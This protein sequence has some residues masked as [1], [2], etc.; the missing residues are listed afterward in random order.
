MQYEGAFFGV[1]LALVGVAIMTSRF[2]DEL[3]DSE[4]RYG[5]SARQRAAADIPRARRQVRFM[6]LVVGCSFIA[7][8]LFTALTDG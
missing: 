3:L 8:G 4:R 1:I 6:Q 7:A 2:T 5:G